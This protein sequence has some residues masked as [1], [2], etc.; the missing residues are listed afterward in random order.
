[1]ENWHDTFCC[2]MTMQ[3]RAAVNKQQNKLASLGCTVLPHPPYFPYLAP[4]DYALF[5]KMNEPLH[6]RKFLTSDDLERGVRNSVCSIPKDWYAATIRKLPQRW[7][8]CTDL[9]ERYVESA[10]VWLVASHQ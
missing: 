6:W 4:S 1:M 3:D 7:E 8:R 9:G 5:N 10:T 2:S